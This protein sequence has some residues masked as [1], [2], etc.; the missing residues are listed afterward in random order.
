M[1]GRARRIRMDSGEG[2]VYEG[3]DAGVKPLNSLVL[4]S[5][6]EFG[7]IRLFVV[8]S[9][10][11]TTGIHYLQYNCVHGYRGVATPPSRRPRR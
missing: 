1:E 3:R 2:Y 11:C 6:C 9:A 5:T 8:A 7:L 10:P 4:M